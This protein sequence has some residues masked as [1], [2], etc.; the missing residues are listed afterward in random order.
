MWVGLGLSVEGIQQLTGQK[1]ARERAALEESEPGEGSNCLARKVF[2]GLRANG[3]SCFW[4]AQD[5][6][7]QKCLVGACTCKNI[8][9]S[10][11]AVGLKPGILYSHGIWQY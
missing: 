9:T 11:G 4:E 1:E 5:D 6:K 10:A 2:T 7:T 8:V 3:V